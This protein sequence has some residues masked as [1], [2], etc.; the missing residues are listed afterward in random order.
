MVLPYTILGVRI[1]GVGWK[2]I[3]SSRLGF[4]VRRSNPEIETP[5]VGRNTSFGVILFLH[6]SS[7][8]IQPPRPAKHPLCLPEKEKNNTSPRGK[9]PLSGPVSPT[10]LP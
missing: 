3:G 6:L 7:H 9:R 1:E 8:S 2:H 4:Q 5:L 10:K